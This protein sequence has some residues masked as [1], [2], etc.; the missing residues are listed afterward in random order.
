MDR[1]NEERGTRQSYT[2]RLFLQVE[3]SHWLEGVR[4]VT[5]SPFCLGYSWDQVTPPVHRGNLCQ[6]IL[7]Q[8]GGS[9][10]R[11]NVLLV[12]LS[13]FRFRKESRTGAETDIDYC[14][15]ALWR[16]CYQQRGSK[17]SRIGQGEKI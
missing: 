2:P 15:L 5:L 10:G 8:P 3:L 14:S 13:L 9:E 16:E 1:W 7:R 11:P 17:G 4:W 12:L 6:Q